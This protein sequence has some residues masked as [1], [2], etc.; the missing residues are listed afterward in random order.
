MAQ[1]FVTREHAKVDRIAC[2][3]LI[4]RFID[5]DA[6]IL[7]VPRDQVVG[8]ARNEGALPF[9]IPDVELG[10]HGPLC[11]FDAF[12][13]KYHLNDPALHKVARIVRGAD[14]DNRDLTKESAGLF[15]VASGFYDLYGS[16]YPTDLALWDAEFP[17][18]DALY[19]YCKN[20][21]Q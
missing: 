18:Y 9:D 17:L 13:E 15:A 11:S 7:Y 3:W 6:E 5:P 10:H 4:K 2:A 8:V 1:K 14:T 16:R 19:E 20:K 12:L 21:H